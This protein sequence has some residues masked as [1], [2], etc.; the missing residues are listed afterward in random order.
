V[1]APPATPSLAGVP[2]S[3]SVGLA[4]TGLE[5]PC[6]GNIGELI[7]RFLPENV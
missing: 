7:W 3:A 1:L 5:G 6:T 4:I 2:G